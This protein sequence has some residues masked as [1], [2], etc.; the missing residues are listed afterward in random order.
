[1]EQATR[2][3]VFVHALVQ[4]Y[5][6]GSSQ[7]VP[8]ERTLN[9]TLT[10]LQRVAFS[11]VLA[12]VRAVYQNNFIVLSPKRQSEPTAAKPGAVDNIVRLRRP[13]GFRHPFRD[14]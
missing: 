12:V 2:S 11:D 9:G 10:F 7:F 14:A 5:R 3:R 6:E 13:F 4:L 1:M 8:Q